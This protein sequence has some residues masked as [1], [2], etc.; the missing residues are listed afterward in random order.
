MSETQAYGTSECPV[1]GVNTPH[2]HTKNSLAN[3]Y[4][5]EWLQARFEELLISWFARYRQLLHGSYG[6]GIH[7]RDKSNNGL[8]TYWW[9]P[10]EMCWVF[11]R[12][13]AA[14]F[15]PPYPGDAIPDVNEALEIKKFPFGKEHGEIKS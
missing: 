10:V 6:M 9:W 7:L 11:F 13:G 14:L 1:C 5:E 2:T 15:T 3:K 12:N 4:R 8:D